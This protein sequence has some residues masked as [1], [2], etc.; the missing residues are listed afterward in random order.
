[1]KKAIKRLTK[2]AFTPIYILM[3]YILMFMLIYKFNV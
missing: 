3:V 2:A 1:M